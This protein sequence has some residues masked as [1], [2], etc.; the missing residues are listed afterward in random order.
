MRPVEEL[1]YL[2]LAAQREG[3]RQLAHE[4]R[5]LGLTPSQAEVLRVLADHQPLTV[6]G[7]G[8]LLVCETGT[9]PSRLV[10][11]L[12]ALGA[13]DRRPGPHDGRE[14]ELA[15][16]DDGAHLAARVSEVE[17]GIYAAL[18]AAAAGR[19]LEETI[20]VLRSF[21]AQ[22]PAGEALDRRIALEAST[23]RAEASP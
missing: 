18:D 1:R 10:D 3:N 4:L 12:V 14:V 13:V 2:V 11:R 21:V 17:V 5:P 7:L 22:R 19:P 8:E 6:R 20:D 16:T 9:N 15:L 23:A